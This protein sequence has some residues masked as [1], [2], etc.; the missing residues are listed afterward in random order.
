MKRA[1]FLLNFAC[2]LALLAGA[3]PVV[4]EAWP[5]AKQL[6]AMCSFIVRVEVVKQPAGGNLVAVREVW[7]GSYSPTNFTARPPEGHIY[8]N[9]GGGATGEFLLF[10][11]AHNHRTSLGTSDMGVPIKDGKVIYPPGPREL[12]EAKTYTL[13]EFKHALGI[14]TEAAA[15]AKRLPITFDIMARDSVLVAHCRA[16]AVSGRTLG[17]VLEVWRGAY[18]PLDFERQPPP[19]FVDVNLGLPKAGDQTAPREGAEFIVLWHRLNQVGGGL[20]QF[21]LVPV[22]D[23]KVSQELHRSGQREEL[24]VA[25]FKQRVSLVPAKPGR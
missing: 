5:T 22:K 7:K 12:Y 11:A 15:T 20:R 17:K 6:G 13:D 10:Y 18:A 24:T 14:A 23:G 9:Y 2:G 25:E 1:A 8:L 4:A 3:L 21:Y 16:E 19:G